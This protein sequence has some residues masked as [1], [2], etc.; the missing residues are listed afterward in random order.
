MVMRHGLI[1]AVL[2]ASLI[3]P[4]VISA[5]LTL[6]VG[7]RIELKAFNK[8]GVPLHREAHSSLVGR[9][10]EGS[11]AEILELNAN[12][13]WLRIQLETND[14]TAWVVSRYVR[15][16]IEGEPAPENGEAPA[17]TEDERQVWTSA[18]ACEQVVNA[19]R[20]MAPQQPDRLRFV[21]WNIRWFP[22]GSSERPGPGDEVQPTDLRWLACVLAWMNADVY[23]L[24]EIRTTEAAREAWESVTDG[25]HGFTGNLWLRNMQACGSGTRQHVGFL[26][27]VSRVMLSNPQDLWQLNGRSDNDG[28]PCKDS[29]RPG[30]YSLLTGVESSGADLH[31]I[32]VHFDSGR[33]EQDHLT[34]RTAFGRIDTA[35]APFLA[36]DQDVIILGDF[37]TMGQD[38]GESAEDEIAAVR[39][40]VQD[41]APG[42]SLVEVTP[43][44]TEYFERKGG[45]LDHVLVAKDMQEALSA[46]ARVT[47]YCAAQNCEELSEL[48]AAYRSLSDHCPLVY[49]IRN[50]DQD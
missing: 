3:A 43:A 22:D 49:A 31:V 35:V 7:Q 42:F 40:L 20:R 32:V 25:L 39:Q 15:R 26:W 48:P 33:K 12:R 27:N 24:Q 29:L 13:H 16:I 45:W 28:E 8:L 46:Q 4:S 21:T 11:K 2:L 30:H 44:C 6:D 47:G 41:E 1:L 14:Q 23:A 10:P 36:Q 37:N 5:Q 17:V 9:A 34:R 18:E 19:G 38:G 50:Q